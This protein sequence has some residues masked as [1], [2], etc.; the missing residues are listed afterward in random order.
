MNF[1]NKITISVIVPFYNSEK[2]LSK[3]IL[4]II[5]QDNKSKFE[6]IMV[7][8]GSTDHSLDIIK[9]FDNNNIKVFSLPENCGPAAA[10]NL[11]LKKAKG[12]YVFFVDAD[13]RIEKNTLSLLYGIACK[14]KV[15]LVLCD[16]KWIENNKNQ[17][18][19]YFFFTKRPFYI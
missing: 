16:S 5:E 8:D 19:K 11:G 18:K 14:T 13:D 9:N 1:V 4:S 7:D 10:R 3:C 12:D 2:H 17:R 6:I 15:D